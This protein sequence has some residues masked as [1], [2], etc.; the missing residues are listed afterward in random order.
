MLSGR[1]HEVFGSVLLLVLEV[2]K[3]PSSSAE[4][5]E[6]NTNMDSLNTIQISDRKDVWEWQGKN[7]LG[8]CVKA[9]KTILQNFVDSSSVYVMTWC[10]WLLK[11]LNIFAWRAEI[12]RIP[13]IEALKSQNIM[14]NATG[15]VFCGDAIEDTDHI[16]TGCIVAVQIWQWLSN[17][18]HTPNVYAFN[19]KDLWEYHNYIGQGETKKNAVHGLIIIGCWFIWKARCEKTFANKDWKIIDIKNN[20]KALGFLWFKNRSKLK[21]VLWSNWCNFNFL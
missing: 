16:F 10:Q 13:T 11:K 5:A 19:V 7:S 9:I 1:A 8:F 6:L 17:W 2:E 14:V 12:G 4:H 21:T 3:P 20:I 18:C 15:C